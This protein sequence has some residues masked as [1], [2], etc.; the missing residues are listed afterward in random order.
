MLVP[1]KA[2]LKRNIGAKGLRNCQTLATQTAPAQT[3]WILQNDYVICTFSS[4]DQTGVYLKTIQRKGGSR[5]YTNHTRSLWQ[6]AVH[7]RWRVGLSKF[8]HPN[9]SSFEAPS[10]TAARSGSTQ[11]FAFVWKKFQIEPGVNKF[12]NVT[13]TASLHDSRD[14]VEFSVLLEDYEVSGGSQTYSVSA[15]CLLNLALDYGPNEADE[16]F[17]D[18]F[19]RGTS[20]A[21]PKANLRAP[22]D[23][24]ENYAATGDRDDK[25]WFLNYAEDIGD[26]P[27][28]GTL[29]HKRAF[30]YSPGRM[31][32][33][34]LSFGDRQSQQGLLISAIDSD[35]FHAKNFQ[36]WSDGER[37]RIMAWDFSDHE[38][39]A[40]GVGGKD[41][42][43]SRH[44]VGWTIRLQPFSSPTR[45]VDYYAGMLYRDTVVPDLEDLGWVPKS[46]KDRVDEGT[47]CSGLADSPFYGTFFGHSSGEYSRGLDN[48]R[49]FQD[50]YTGTT[51]TTELP[52]VPHHIENPEISSSPNA[53][54]FYRTADRWGHD[55]TKT[56]PS[57]YEAPDYFPVNSDYSGSAYTGTHSH[58]QF[59]GHYILSPFNL[60]TGSQWVQDY[61]GFG[62]AV[63][64]VD[65]T[66]IAP[67]GPADYVTAVASGIAD[68]EAGVA[69]GRNHLV[70]KL[71]TNYF[72]REHT[73]CFDCPPVVAKWGQ[74]AQE[75][76]ESN[77]SIYR[78][79]AGLFW[80]GCY[81]DEHVWRDP[82]DG[83]WVTGTHP[84]SAFSHYHNAAYRDTYDAMTTG[85][86]S[87]TD[88]ALTGFSYEMMAETEYECDSLLQYAP[89]SVNT[90]HIGTKRWDQIC[91]VPT[92]DVLLGNL[93]LYTVTPAAWHE[94]T[95]TWDLVYKDRSV[96][97]NHIA[98]HFGNLVGAT[99][100]A[101]VGDIYF[102]LQERT[103]FSPIYSS[104]HRTAT[105]EERIETNQAWVT[106]DLLTDSRIT[107]AYGDPEVGPW[108]RQYS[109]IPDNATW[110][111]DPTYSGLVDYAKR[112]MRIV[113]ER[114]DFLL[115]GRLVQPLEDWVTPVQ[116]SL[117]L[118]WL[119]SG[120]RYSHYDYL[121]GSD[122]SGESAVMHSVHRGRSGEQLLVT[123]LN[124]TTGS[125][126]FSGYF[127]PQ[128]YEFTEAYT[129]YAMN[130]D[131]GS[132]GE[133]TELSEKQAGQAYRFETTLAPTSAYVLQIVPR[134]GLVGE[135]DICDLR[136]SY[137]PI[138]YSY[139]STELTQDSVSV[140]YSY[141]SQAQTELADPIVGHKA[142]ATQS[143]VNN[144]PQWMEMRQNHDSC[145]W[146]LV[147]TWGQ[148]L[149]DSV[150]LTQQQLANLFLDT[151]DYTQKDRIYSVSLPEVDYTRTSK[152][153]LRNAS[154]SVP[155]CA[156]ARLPAGWTDYH[157]P[158]AQAVT[159]TQAEG[160]LGC[161]AVGFSSTGS[162]G[163]VVELDNQ[164]I[165]QLAGSV[166][167]LN[168]TGD[169][170]TL[171]LSV[172]LL[173]GRSIAREVSSSSA[174]G[175]W[176][177][178][179]VTIQ[180]SEQVYRAQLVV[181]AAPTTSPIY[182]SA[183][184][185]EIGSQASA[186]RRGLDDLPWL[187]G[188]SPLGQLQAFGERGLR[189]SPKYD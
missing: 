160:T 95:P 66:G 71:D 49:V 59:G 104:Q 86:A 118:E 5:A 57:P 146:Q 98:G 56:G 147:N 93:G 169:P 114:K 108:S 153:L 3:E 48:L 79:T 181:R 25:V 154:F 83:S 101:G 19:E 124:W 44:E 139:A 34:M 174:Y 165:D 77:V 135:S 43:P 94:H 167:V 115:H 175:D 150:E 21:N 10:T 53:S 88:S 141:D 168:L 172:E 151:T 27:S 97:L 85:F 170:V 187:A 65:E 188:N 177:R 133:L 144:L 16:V 166:Y 149:E 50:L 46:F 162:L 186:W 78:D 105:T 6:V 143:I 158:Q 180:P 112:W 13:F 96:L 107:L 111:A 42:D 164:V 12:F 109:G 76:A 159:R 18:C 82:D 80:Q 29:S 23:L 189:I 28:P 138:R 37:L 45:W 26:Q 84:R 75:A 173:D 134:S 102:Q 51:Q 32:I 126:S 145:G 125:Q 40:Y 103:G 69:L 36:W 2:L 140:S 33:P 72:I 130:T 185:L 161:Y 131:E 62:F 17:T 178:L 171:I 39:D 120:P 132:A 184:Q 63:V 129:V 119:R 81:A 64:E 106:A 8:I 89:Y 58:H 90:P 15:V 122:V 73:A 87:G 47:Y 123:C 52:Y 179:T 38:F 1:R 91:M 183:P 30:C 127:K 176:Q 55:Y 14:Q 121:Q 100:N 155:D 4:S 99:G 128:A 41:G 31:S 136:T 110:T 163:Q 156:R 157:K 182:I 152:N 61:S 67:R 24:S 35:G 113:H 117:M 137:A 148:M 54:G 11:S 60:S 9:K 7:R 22:R 116:R 20:T 142:A 68:Y 74:L 70:N 92:D